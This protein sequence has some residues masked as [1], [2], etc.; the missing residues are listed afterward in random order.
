M[1]NTFK[2]TGRTYSIRF[3]KILLSAVISLEVDDAT[4]SKNQCLCH[5]FYEIECIQFFSFRINSNNAN[6]KICQG[7]V[8]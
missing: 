8:W 3:Y 1:V 7:T 5:Y 6:R 2:Y 4:V